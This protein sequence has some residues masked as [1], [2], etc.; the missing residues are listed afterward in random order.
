MRIYIA[1][2]YSKGDVAVNVREAIAAGDLMLR[3]GHTP[4]VPH[5]THFWHMLY[6]HEYHKWLAYDKEWLRLC[7]AVWRIPGE[8]PGADE[9]VS[10]ANSLN[11]PV[12][13]SYGEINDIS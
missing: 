2:P 9:E 5:L 10:L 3:K 8:S 12:Y 6:P 7:N 1:G 13:Y 4:Y 11:I